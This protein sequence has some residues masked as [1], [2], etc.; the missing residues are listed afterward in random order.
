MKNERKKDRQSF[1]QESSSRQNRRT[2]R[3]LEQNL[4]VVWVDHLQSKKHGDGKNDE[5]HGC[6]TSLCPPYP[7][8][9]LH[10]EALSDHPT[11][12]VQDHPQISTR[13]FLDH[14]ISNKEAHLDIR[15]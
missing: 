10:T 6:Q 13:L 15:H 7:H 11:Q 9:A 12:L 3:I 2:Q 1:L 5:N 14:Q 4:R 8:V